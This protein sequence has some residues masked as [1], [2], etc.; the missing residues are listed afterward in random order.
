MRQPA[1]SRTK[2]S[3]LSGATHSTVPSSAATFSSPQRSSAGSPHVLPTSSL[4]ARYAEPVA[5]D[6]AFELRE[7]R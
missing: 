7:L 3:L 5:A 6:S 2:R 1:P 4:R